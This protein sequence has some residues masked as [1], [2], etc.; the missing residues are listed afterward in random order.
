MGITKAVKWIAGEDCGCKERQAVLN[1]IWPHRRPRCLTEGE[2][3]DWTAFRE[4]ES[5]EIAQEDQDLIVKVWNGVFQTRK[6][7]RPGK[8]CAEPWQK[9]INEINSVYE[10]YNTEAADAPAQEGTKGNSNDD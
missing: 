10:T 5:T 6:L 1:E 8:C 3:N 4:S 9:M 2:Y 7:H